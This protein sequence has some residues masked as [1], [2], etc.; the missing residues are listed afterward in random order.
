VDIEPQSGPVER[1]TPYARR[2]ALLSREAARLWRL[3]AE[4]S[5]LRSPRAPRFIIVLDR[6]QP[7]GV[8]L[9]P[10]DADEDDFRE[11][12]L[13]ERQTEAAAFA[14]WLLMSE[15]PKHAVPTWRRAGNSA[16]ETM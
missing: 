7:E 6:L 5:H 1:G 10:S 2:V 11:E 3:L 16:K 4:F 9:S 12:R 15:P 13:A 14:A 8:P